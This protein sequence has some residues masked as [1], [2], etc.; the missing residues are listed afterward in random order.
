MTAR[1][2]AMKIFTKPVNVW[3]TAAFCCL[4]WGSAFPAIK[5]GYRLLSISADDVPTILL[6]AGV[7]FTLAGLLT[8]LI[9]SAI[10]KRL[11][12]PHKKAVKKIAVLSVFQTVLQYIFFYLG[13]AYTT[14]A[15]GSVI[16]ATSVFFALL[17][18]SLLFRFEKIRLNKIA[19]CAIG[20]IGVLMVSLDAFRKTGGTPLGEGLILLSSIAYAFS[21]VFMKKYAADDHPAMLSGWQFVLG[22]CVLT[23]CG[24]CS[25][26]RLHHMSWQAAVLIGY[27]AL[28]SAAAYSLWSIL[29]KYNE[30][31]KVAVCGFMIP[32]FGVL[33]SAL[34]GDGAGGTG[35]IVVLALLLVVAGIILVNLP[36]KTKKV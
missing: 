20:F 18:S 8:V 9:F 22:G 2:F 26:G 17:I 34:F 14:G 13:L 35:I 27:L 3:L 21:S 25:G 24:F 1:C 12:L 33:L 32:V 30:V 28:L 15:R 7:R 10:E 6:F 23:I 31:S 36:D 4:L 5:A 29:L 11:L 19:G 16:N